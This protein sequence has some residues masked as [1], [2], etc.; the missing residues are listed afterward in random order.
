MSRC[1]GW[2]P[3]GRRRG[4]FRTVSA[5]VIELPPE[6]APTPA[7]ETPQDTPAEIAV[8]DSTGVPGQ[9]TE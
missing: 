9:R 2:R 3:Q 8:E 4:G 1:Y 6:A 5:E 7:P